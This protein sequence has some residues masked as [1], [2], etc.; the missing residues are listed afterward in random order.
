MPLPKYG[1]VKFYN[2]KEI[3]TS[4]TSVGHRENNDDRFKITKA[5]IDIGDIY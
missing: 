1:R 3:S 2:L 5:E 4:W